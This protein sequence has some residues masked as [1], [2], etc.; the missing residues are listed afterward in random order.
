[1]SKRVRTLLRVSSRQQLHDDDIPLQRAEAHKYIAT[2]KDWEFDKEYIERAVSAFKN[3]AE[4]RDVLQEILIDAQNGEF[5]ILLAYM[6]DRIGRLEEYTFY[7][8]MLNNLGVEVWT[9]NDGQLKTEDDTDRL[10]T[11]LKFWQNGRESKKTSKRVHDAQIES[12]RAGKFVGGKAPYGYKLVD[13][14][15]ISNHGRLLKKLVIVEE[16]A[17]VVRKIYSLAIH[18]GYGYEKIAKY[19]NSE[20]IPAPTLSQWKG[21]TV[22]SILKNPIYMGY[23]AINRRKTVYTK[24]KLDR[25]DWILSENQ[26]PEIVIVSEQD[27]ERAQL[28]RESRKNRIETSKQKSIE[29]FEEQY[30]VPFSSSGKLA[31]IGLC[32]CGYCGKRLKNGSYLNR[33][34]TKDGEKKVSYV[35]RYTCPEKCAERASY[36]QDYLES[37]VFAIVEKYM[38]NL[39]TVDISEEIKTMQKQ[40]T[41]GTDKELQS[42]RKEIQKLKVDIETLEEKIPDAIRGDYYFSAEKLSSMIKEKEQKIV[43]LA[44]QEKQIQQKVQQSQFASKDLEKFISIIPNWKEE[45]QNADMATKKMLLSALIDS[46]VVKDM[47][48]RIKFKIRLENFFDFTKEELVPK[49]IHHGVPGKGIQFQYHILYGI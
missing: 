11:Y 3:K 31:L 41:A 2:H 16:Q 29:A 27:W 23:Y 5:D 7:V 14:G 40:L 6:S 8:V 38:D 25:K 49:T 42:I 48:I 35:G 17:E 28:I 13:S 10:T 24:K 33:W 1:M 21:G 47:D 37:I 19:L 9:I 43:S 39:K 20:G 18:Q 22:A 26:I 46:I 12:V 45:F 32:Q 30:N 4:E 34:T 36:S 15:L 44:E